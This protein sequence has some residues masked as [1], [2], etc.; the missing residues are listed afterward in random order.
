MNTPFALTPVEK[1]W[2]QAQE[3]FLQHVFSWTMA[4]QIGVILLALFLAHRA[5]GAVR[6][7]RIRQQ[8]EH[9]IGREAPFLRVIEPMFATIFIWIASRTAHHL[10]WARDGL[11]AALIISVALVFIRLFNTGMKNRFWVRILS[12]YV[13]LW[14]ALTISHIIDPWNNYLRHIDFQ[15]DKVQVSLL[16]I[17]RAFFLLFILYWL[18]RNLL[19]IWRFWLTTR[20]GLTPAVQVLLYKLGGIFLFVASS[21]FVLHYLGLDL[22]VF[23]LFS[24]ALGLGLGFGLQK[25]FANV[26]S[27]FILL[28]DKSIK[29]GDVIEVKDTYGWINYLGSRY[30]SVIS[31]NGTEHLI[32][33]ENLVTGEVI[34]WSYSNN[35]I[36]L[37]VPIGVAYGSDLEKVRDLMLE[38][39]AVARVLKDPEPSCRLLGFGDNAINLELRVWINDPREGITVVKS[40]IFWGIWRRFQEHGI[41]IPYP[42][43]DVHI[44]TSCEER[45]RTKD[46]KG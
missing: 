29:P 35:L 19:K 6:S 11:N 17:Y 39:A 3:Y 13:W 40:D 14:A 4:V 10:G 26:I 36:R 41:E 9:P 2:L 31:R 12:V 21:I 24:G 28:A 5:T 44:K 33:N 18:S 32:P 38:S 25:V 22:T 15:L 16:T 1:I 43:R 45:L 46:E 8:E 20:S 30:I 7:W 37:K 27:G 42:Q 23:A 34:N